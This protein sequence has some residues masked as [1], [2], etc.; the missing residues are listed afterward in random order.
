MHKNKLRQFIIGSGIILSSV[1]LLAGCSQFNERPLR[2]LVIMPGAEC[3]GGL[4]AELNVQGSNITLKS[5]I[6][7]PSSE[8]SHWDGMTMETVA[9]HTLMTVSAQCYAESGEVIGFNKSRGST[10][11]SQAWQTDMV[12]SVST[13]ALGS[14]T[15]ACNHKD[16]VLEERGVEMCIGTFDGKPPS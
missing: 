13:A 15:S 3:A 1:V 4:M 16:F 8:S 14:G 10:D 2:L 6:V 9:R 5:P 11:F 7:R 12:I